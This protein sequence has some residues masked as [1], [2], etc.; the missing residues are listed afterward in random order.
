MARKV[1]RSKKIFRVLKR[2]WFKP[3]L[4]TIALSA[5][6]YFLISHTV[7]L[8]RT[9]K[10]TAPHFVISRLTD[11]FDKTEFMHLLLTIQ[12]LQEDSKAKKQ[13][14]TFVNSPYPAISCPTYLE[15][16][17]KQMN[18]SPLA[19]QIRVK[20]LFSMYESYDHLKRLDE[21][22]G[23][24]TAEIEQSYLPRELTPQL[25]ILNQERAN[26]LAKE[27]SVEEYNFIKDYSGLVQQI[28]QEN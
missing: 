21:T 14:I 16:Q 9:I 8:K 4:Y 11:D 22:I 17:L 6:I 28:K 23:F 2:K 3:A 1:R 27:F 15:K 12:E 13:L 7:I 5:L 25:E 19:F 18:W 24:L 26:L 20:K 10:P